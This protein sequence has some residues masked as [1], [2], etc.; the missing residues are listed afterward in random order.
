MAAKR[1]VAVIDIGKTNAKLALIDM[2]DLTEIAVLTKPNK[3]IPGPP[4]P[5]FDVEALWDFVL[6]GLGEFQRAH[7]IDAISVTT[8]GASFALLDAQGELATPVLDYEFTGP[9]ELATAYG[10]VRPD[11]SQTGSPRLPMGLNAGAQLFWLFETDPDIRLRTRWIVTYPQYWVARLTG[12]V[13]NEA[14]SLGCHTDLWNPYEGRY[15]SLAEQQGWAPLMAP[16]RGSN[17]KIGPVLPEIADRT[18]LSSDTAVVCG[19]H[20]SNASLYPHL[21]NSQSP[22]AV[23]STGT[24]VICMAIGGHEA[25]LDPSRD[26]LMNVNGLG[27]AVPSSRFMGGREF[28]IM[29]RDHSQTYDVTDIDHILDQKIMLLPSVEQSSGPFPGRQ[30]SWTIDEAGL[31]DGERFVAVSYYLALMTASCLELIGA[32][33]AIIVEGPFSENTLFCEML[34]AATDRQVM[35]ATGTGTS[36]GAALLTCPSDVEF[37]L[38]TRKC[39]PAPEELKSYA[40]NWAQAVES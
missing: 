8:H 25:I 32:A 30:H 24:W 35:S 31:S 28:E 20:D 11:F 17:E 19:I 1:I 2:D 27:Q 16:L 22:F 5:H 37:S 23:V 33:G 38:A 15:S 10:T 6:D 36:V 12:V 14:T 13:A 29:M 4:Y 34:S 7:S 40:R 21:L 3:I 18:G 26:S 9:D 39:L